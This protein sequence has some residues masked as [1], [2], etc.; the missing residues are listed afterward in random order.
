MR[1]SLV[2]L[3]LAVL[4]AFP[5]AAELTLQTVRSDKVFYD[6]GSEAKFEVVVANSDAAEAKCTLRVELVRD[7]DT[8]K[9]LA[10][11]AIAVP[12]KGQTPWSGA[13]KLPTVLGMAVTATLL[14]D[15]QPF[16]EKSDYFNCARSVHQVLLFGMGNWGAWQFSGMADVNP[17]KAAESP[18]SDKARAEYARSFAQEWRDTYGNC[19]EKFGWAP[20]D[21]DDLAPDADRWWAGQTAYNECK[22]NMIAIIN[23]MHAN[24]VKVV[25]YGK[26]AAGGIVGYERL[27]RRPDLSPYANGRPWLENYSAAYLDWI[28]A[29][30]PPHPGE[31][32]AIPGTPEEMEKSGYTGSAYF[33]PFLPGGGQNWC[34]VWYD[35]SLPE[36]AETGIGELAKSAQ[37]FG[38]DG[39][40]FD[41]EFF[42]NRVQ[43]LDGSWNLPKK[44]NVEPLNV[45]LTQQM[46]KTCWAVNPRYLFGYNA[47]TDP[48][49]SI[50]LK[51]TP[52]GFQEK[53]KGDGLIGNECMAFPGD[54]P[55]L[56]Y[57]R[58]ARREAEIV[59]FYGGHYA[60]YAFNRG[61]NNL[62]NYIFQYA[63]RAHQM[64]S[65][66]SPERAWLNRSATRFSRLLWDDSLTTWRGAGAKLSV[67]ASRDVWWQDFAAVG[68]SPDG[69]TRY[70]IH[71]FNA[72]GAPT[73]LAKNQLPPEPATNVRLR[74]KDLPAVRNAW[75]V[76]MVGTAAEEIKPNQGLFE[77]GEVPIWKILVVDVNAPKPPVTWEAP[78]AAPASGPSSADL[79]IAPQ[80][81]TSTVYH[82]DFEPGSGVGAT[83]SNTAD[84]V[85]DPAAVD[86]MAMLAKPTRPSGLFTWTYLYPRVP[87]LYR[88]TFRLKVSDNKVDKPVFTLG[89]NL[90]GYSP[91]VQPLA[92]SLKYVPKTLKPTDFD[93]PNVYQNFSIEYPAPDYGFLSCSVAYNAAAGV[94]GWWDCAV[95]ELVRPWT[96]E[97]L[98]EHYR[99]LQRP[100]GLAK[101]DN[102]A[103]DALVVRGLYNRLYQIDAA[104]KAIPGSQQRDAYTSY[105]QQQGTRLTGYQWDWKPMWDLDVIVLADVETKGLNYG[106]VLMLSEWVK[107]GGGLL[108]LGGPLTLG[109]D[110]N[111][112]RAWP[113]LLPVDLKGPWEIRKCDPPV[114]VPAWGDAAVMYRHLVTPKEGAEVLLQGAGGEPLL[115]GRGYGKGRVAVFAGTVLGEAPAG[116]EDFWKTDA[117]KAQLTKA[118]SWVAGK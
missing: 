113:L 105:H 107:D 16:A 118:I 3:T 86:G 77:V 47:A 61:G 95:S 75:V 14:R 7:V 9:T 33:Q 79:A 108:V 31:A 11:Q 83:S 37:M 46:K 101:N 69:G 73:T 24:G 72:P 89:T 34:A 22:T 29:M 1:Y 99:P 60:T 6:P 56:E 64:V 76:D 18:T 109:Q 13:M 2:V 4:T 68:D 27:R 53:C 32:R 114:K 38:F 112:A 48:I 55:W 116:S 5:A 8:R 67:S 90:E 88:S 74:W 54:V 66:S 41:G 28:T 12:A 100:A 49:W 19:L 45:A 43:R 23:A 26:E 84:P 42:A 44:T 110:D 102:G 30:G 82:N 96:D 35:C 98:A 93:K 115:V 85:R 78:P 21:F 70:V 25:T 10:E 20:S 117:W 87:G 15:G 63:L 94:E 57:C 59:R 52:L 65:Y 40:R 92:A 103:L 71:I 80:P 81:S 51:N 17:D 104:L 62:Y 39:V 36:I 111:M 91:E 106:Q 50:P 97:E 58:A